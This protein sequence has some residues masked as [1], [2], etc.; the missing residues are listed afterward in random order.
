MG[1]ISIRGVKTDADR[2]QFVNLPFT[3][4]RGNKFWVPPLK[5]DEL[6]SLQ[7]ENNPA[8]EFCTAK[9]WTAHKDDKC[10]GR[11]GGIINRLALEKTGEKKVR[12][13]R[14]EMIDDAEVADALF[15]TV[16]SWAKEQGMEGVHGPL[17]FSNLDQQGMLIEGFDHLPSI[18]SV[19][20]LPYYQKHLERLGYEKEMD[21]VEFRLKLAEST[22][23]KAVKLNNIIKKRYGLSVVHFKKSSEAMPYGKKI[24]G[25]LNDAF[26]EIYAVVP[27]ND[28]MIDFYVA[29]YFKLINPNYIKVVQNSDGELVGFIVGLP[30]LSEAMQKANGSLFPF[31]WWHI[32]QA[33]KKPE[34]MDLLLTGIHP[35]MQGQGVSAVLITELQQVLIDNGVR[36]VETT[37]IIE[38]NQKAI[39][40]WKNYDHIQH[41]RR[42]SYVKMF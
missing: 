11:I 28:K 39:Q 5:V 30:S 27:F 4:Y 6:K 20:H 1:E 37:G 35:K 21:W 7:P 31:G 29:K 40:H 15:N 33:L 14:V 10:V 38:T 41:K 12:L 3:I 32:M 26:A 25:I 34:V 2:K 18:A 13:T 22:P 23:E 17:G 36:E 42:R 24:F 8:F 16:E 9:F 19:F